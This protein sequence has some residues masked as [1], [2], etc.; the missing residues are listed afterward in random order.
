M[1]ANLALLTLLVSGM[2][3]IVGGCPPSGGDGANTNTTGGTGNAGGTDGTGGTAG[4]GGTSTGGQ[5]EAFLPSGVTLD[6]SELPEDADTATAKA[7][8][9]ERDTGS[10]YERVAL[11]SA[12][13][14]HR[15]HR[16]ADRGLALAA[17]IHNDITDPAQ[18]QVTG[19]FQVGTQLVT[20]KADFAAFDFDGD[21]TPD[22]SGSPGQ[23]PVAVRIW[24]DQGSGYERFMCAVI[25]QRPT[26]ANLG[27]GKFYAKPSAVAADVPTNVQ[28]F[29]DYDRTD[30]AHK[31]NLA[32]VT[33]QIHPRYAL[34]WGLARVDVRTNAAGGI[35]K[36]VRAAY[37]FADN[38]YGLW[39]LQSAVH[40]V[41]GGP[42]LLE[43]AKSA[44]G[45]VAIDFTNVCVNLIDRTLATHG[46]CDSFD[47]QDMTLL[48][49]PPGNAADFP[50][51]FP[52]Q[53]TF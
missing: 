41:V 13:I 7:I 30:P 4:T 19:T 16:L 17:V 44:G 32:Y 5:V 53:P 38:P 40:Y 52:E 25:T 2:L 36:T 47:L 9:T 35:E 22:G 11:A 46:E 15:F 3:L 23:S 20:Y 29:V 51:T 27:A 18:T 1:R 6:I 37:D 31:W 28:F 33:G 10:A 42:G 34:L 48:D 21:G 14:V 24:A 8:Q 49:T 43:S 50:A 45:T 12:T 26:A 39:W